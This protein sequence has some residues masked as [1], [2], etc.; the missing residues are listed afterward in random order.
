MGANRSKYIGFWQ[1]NNTNIEVDSLSILI[2]TDYKSRLQLAYSIFNSGRVMMG[3][4]EN[5]GTEQQ[6]FQV[7]L[8]NGD[9]KYISRLT[10][11]DSACFN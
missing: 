8:V 11:I 6:R 5:R 10:Q 9:V 1:C 7:P 3:T 2:R 4:E